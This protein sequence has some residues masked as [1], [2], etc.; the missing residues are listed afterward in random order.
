MSQ[1]TT[2]SGEFNNVTKKTPPKPR[3]LVVCI[4][5]MERGSSLQSL[6]CFGNR[7]LVVLANLGIVVLTSYK[8]IRPGS[9]P[10][11]SPNFHI[12]E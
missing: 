10:L 5:D 6:F 2:Y 8:Y 4:V 9:P 1:Y 3:F 11:F 7:H 12:D